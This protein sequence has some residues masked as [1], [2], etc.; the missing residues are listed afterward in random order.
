MSEA[1]WNA[2]PCD[3]IRVAASLVWNSASLAS[4]RKTSFAEQQDSSRMEPSP[5]HTEPG[6]RSYEDS[7]S[8]E[9]LPRAH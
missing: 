7:V 6:L 4:A 8:M 9:L 2:K 1:R 5:S 3:G